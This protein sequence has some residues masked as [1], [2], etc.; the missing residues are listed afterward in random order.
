MCLFLR[1]HTASFTAYLMVAAS[2]STASLCKP[3]RAAAYMYANSQTKHNNVKH[4]YLGRD[5]CKDYI[6]A[7]IG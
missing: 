3:M 2:L 5:S 4:S 6:L 7:E 1:L